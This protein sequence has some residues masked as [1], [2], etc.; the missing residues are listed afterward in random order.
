[1]RRPTETRSEWRG[2]PVPLDVVERCKAGD[3]EAWAR[4]VR[5]THREVYTLC[6]RILRDPDDAADATQDA[7]IKA[8]RGLK[9]FRG[10]AQFSTW[11]YRVATNAAI[12]RHRGRKRRRAHEIE[13][14]DDVL[15]QLPAARSAET[16][17][18]SRIDAA[19]VEAALDRLPDHYRLAVALRDVYGQSIAEISDKLGI[20]E[21]AAK[22]RI[23][24]G[25]RRLRDMLLPQEEGEEG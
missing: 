25:R 1:M 6:L 21:T 10:D 15:G 18:S 7:Y 17:A 4:L 13:A 5:A 20:T 19:A 22:V 14:H 23:H 3:Q 24:R 2:E 9:G 8:W 11:L 12:S 16:E